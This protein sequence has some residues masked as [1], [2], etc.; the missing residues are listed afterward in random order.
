MNHGTARVLSVAC[1]ILIA[2]RADTVPA[3]EAGAALAPQTASRDTRM[4]LCREIDT[5]AYR[6]TFPCLGDLNGDGRVDFLLYRQGPQ[7]TPGYLV[8][9]D[10][11]GNRL[12]ERGDASITTHAPDGDYREPALRGIALI[13]DVDRDGRSEV[14]AEVWEDGRPMLYVLEGA[15]GKVKH[16]RPSPFDLQVRGGRRSRCHPVARIAYLRGKDE[17]PAI[18]LKYGASGRVPCRAVALDATLATLWDLE[19]DRNAMAHVPTVADVD[20]DG[21]EEIVLGTM[22]IDENGKPLWQKK[23]RHHADCTGIIELASRPEKGIL[24]GICNTGPAFCLAHDGKTLWEKTTQEVS[25]GQGIWAGN[26][27]EEE[28]GQEAIILKS[29]HVG[30]FITVRGHDGAPLAAFK[31]HDEFGGYPDFP[32]VVNWQSREVQSLWIPVD[33]RLVDGR[34][35]VVAELGPD[36]ERVRKGVQWGTTKASVAAQAFALDLCGDAR[37]ELVIYQPYGGE[38]IFIFTQPDSDGREKPYVHQPAAY[39]IRSYF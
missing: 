14:V 32:C 17:P 16:S 22:L 37:D 9:L 10:H 5:A 2:F 7:T 28:P 3:A 25:H 11:E 35:Q 29:G 34:G 27:I 33:R 30:D 23:A 15:T 12:W 19:V 20:A 39:N 36:E 4:K 6:G 31:H 18:V 24:I 13:F 38:K 1:V 21:R 26:F 8:A